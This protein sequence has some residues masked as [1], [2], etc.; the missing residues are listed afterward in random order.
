MKR[1]RGEP[2][3]VSVREDSK[4]GS[5]VDRVDTYIHNVFHLGSFLIINCM[6]NLNV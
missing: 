6:I 2:L 4:G 5:T 3:V 1:K